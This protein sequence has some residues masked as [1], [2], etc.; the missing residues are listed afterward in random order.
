MT[1]TRAVLFD[2]G[3]TLLTERRSRDALYLDVLRPLGARADEATLAM[4]KDRVEREM[5]DGALRP[6]TEPWFREFVRRLLDALEID[7]EAEA[8]RASIA[9]T[10]TRPATYRVFDDVAPTL[11]AL[12]AR[13]LRL[14]VVS[15]WSPFLPELLGG[16]GLLRYF[17][18]L[19]VSAIEGFTK[20]DPRLFAVALDRLD[21]PADRAVH[22]GDHPD[23][24]VAGAR[25]AGVRAFLL[26]RAATRDDGAL[27]LLHRLDALPDLLGPR[28]R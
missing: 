26:D 14:A 12:R 21:V 24:D 1:R 10:F 27:Q 22:V 11:A 2:A 15:N 17:E 4:L 8:V 7:A 3:G 5:A 18:T 23:R 19:A 6:Y 20:P 25:A 28:A 9:D 16:L 13:G